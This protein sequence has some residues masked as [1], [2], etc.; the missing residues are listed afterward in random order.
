MVKIH[1]LGGPGS[2][3]TTLAQA[4]S[5]RFHIPHYDLDRVNLEPKRAVALAE[6]PA[7]V[8][9]GIYLI[10]TEP[11]LYHADYIVLLTTSWPIAAERIIRRHILN[12]L[13]GTQLYPGING[14]KLLFKLLKDTRRYYLNQKLIGNPSIETLHSYLEAHLEIVAPPTEDFARMYFETYREVVA[15]PSEKFVRMYLDRYKEKIFLV[16]D[17]ADRERLLELLAKI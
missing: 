6:Q 5:S 15:P 12:S 14:I 7:W 10:I 3:K 9:E 4:L 17:M 16:K 1:I 13:R 8:T 11:M 2:G